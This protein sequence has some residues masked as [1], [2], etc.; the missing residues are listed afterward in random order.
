M[1]VSFPTIS[2]ARITQL[3]NN[4]NPSMYGGD[5]RHKGI[6]YGT[7]AGTPVYA[8]MDGT[9]SVAT[10]AQTGYGRHIRLQH[11]DGSM[12]IYG[13]LT[14]LLVRVGEQVRAGQEIG[15]S[16]GDPND[17]IDGD[18]LST[19]AHL[20]W[21]IRPPGKTSTDQGAVDPKEYCLQYVPAPVEFAECIAAVGLNVRSAPMTTAPSLFLLMRKETVRVVEHGV[22]GWVRLHGLRPEWCSSEYLH[23]TGNTRTMT[24]SVETFPEWIDAEKLARLWAAHPELHAA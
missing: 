11:L 1:A 23:F 24:V 15:K 16:G 9:V 10:V 5:G 20:H 6:D 19:G 13:H 8:C 3:F 12:S 17:G 14:K 4:Y 2:T 7:P 18:G 22:G 21:E